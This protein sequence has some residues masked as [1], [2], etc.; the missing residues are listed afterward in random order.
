MMMLANV[1]P[2]TNC[3]PSFL[4]LYNHLFGTRLREM[5]E[6]VISFSEAAKHICLRD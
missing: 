3:N 5:V 6:N 1:Q 4:F 2:V